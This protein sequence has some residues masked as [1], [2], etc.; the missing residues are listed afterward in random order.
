MQ[1]SL[2]GRSRAWAAALAFALLA[3]GPTQA[4]FAAENPAWPDIRS[5]Y[6]EGNFQG[7]RA[8]LERL[9][10]ANPQDREAHY[11]LALIHWRLENYPAAAASWRRVL[12]L[13]PEGPF[14]KDAELWLATYGDLAVLSPGRATPR[15]QASPTPRSLATPFAV[16]RPSATPFTITLPAT[17][18]PL[19]TLEPLPSATPPVAIATPA[20]RATAT[21][22]PRTPWLQAQ[23][24]GNSGGRLRSRNAKPGYFKALDGTFEFVPPQG[25][26]LLDEGV[27]GSERRV[28]FGPVS[29]LSVQGSSGEQPPTLMIVWR[30]LPELKRFRA[31]QRVAR[32]R[33]LLTI[34][35]ATYG[36]GA[37][38][39]ARFGV[40]SMRVTQRQGSWA[41]DTW[42]F[43]QH[44]RLYAVTYGGEAAALP[45]HAPAVTKSLA[46]PIFYP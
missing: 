1:T 11:Y 22:P 43:F 23:P 19:P 21:P 27:D 3:A 28:L 12:A 35:A 20:P 7:A 42:L 29:T 46:T 15:P 30:E 25:F 16:S 18:A 4:A 24:G 33:Q 34:E 31:D 5:D 14:G 17:P 37:R 44:D 32:E 8:S 40:P 13:D 26:V 9:V 45:R 2:L 41:A 38:L 10:A 36:P 39:E 6:R